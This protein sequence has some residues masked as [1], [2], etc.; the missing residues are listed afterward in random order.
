MVFKFDTLQPLS[1]I[2]GL[3]EKKLSGHEVTLS[4][5]G[6]SLEQSKLPTFLLPEQEKK[7]PI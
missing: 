5:T 2:L 3:R 4:S 1:R 6:G 7:N